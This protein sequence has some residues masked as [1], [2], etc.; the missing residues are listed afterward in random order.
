[1]TNIPQSFNARF[2]D[3]ILDLERVIQKARL[4]DKISA[5]SQDAYDADEDEITLIQEEI[6]DYRARIRELDL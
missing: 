4:I 3:T 6:T 2:Q 1:M 5:R